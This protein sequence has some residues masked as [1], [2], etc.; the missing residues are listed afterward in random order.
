[1]SREKPRSVPRAKNRF[2]WPI[3]L[4]AALAVAAAVMRPHRGGLV[5]V[6]GDW[7]VGHHLASATAVQ[8]YEHALDYN[9]DRLL[10]GLAIC[11]LFSFYWMLESKNRAEDAAPESRGSASIHQ[12]LVGLSQLLIFLPLPR[13]TQRL[14][15]NSPLIFGIGLAVELG[16]VALAVASR[17]ALG[18]NWSREVRVAVGHE[19][20]RSGP[21]AR[22]R[23]PIY[24][25]AICI[26]LGLAIQSGL[27]SAFL[28][29][30]LLIL[31]YVRKIA[32]E[33][34]LL[35][36]AFGSSFDQYRANSWALIPFLI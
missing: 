20:V 1:M 3:V 18:R 13:F 23:H 29:I 10:P 14:L 6:A 4:F 19:L 15:P 35:G 30:V 27:S 9:I 22:V 28:G 31:A 11:V 26:S 25:G 32:L 33:E 34:R 8:A 21:Y 5:T 24:T 17:R 12:L 2:S 7:A 36:E 16:G